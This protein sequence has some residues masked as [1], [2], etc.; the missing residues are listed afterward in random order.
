MVTGVPLKEKPLDRL[1]SNLEQGA[2]PIIGRNYMRKSYWRWFYTRPC[3][4]FDLPDCIRF[5]NIA[6]MTLS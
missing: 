6:A 4:T 3:Y 5:A 1:S 2:D